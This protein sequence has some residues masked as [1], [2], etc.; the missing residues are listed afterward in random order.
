M[1]LAKVG[2]NIGKE[3]IAWTKTSTK[4]LLAT[5]PVKVN[6]QDLKYAPILEKDVVQ[7]DKIKVIKDKLTKV[8]SSEYC[9]MPDFMARI[10]KD[11]KEEEKLKILSKMFEDSKFFSRVSTCEE[12]YGKNF[13]FAE[14]MSKLSK[15]TSQT[16]TKGKPLEDVLKQIS[17]GYY[18]TRPGS[19]VYRGSNNPPNTIGTFGR[20]DSWTT[21]YGDDCWGAYKEYIER[22][23]KQ[24]GNR[25]T[26][27][28]KFTLTRN[29][30][31]PAE[32]GWGAF[33]QLMVHPYP[34]E[35]AKNMEI[36]SKRYKV[37]QKLV[38]EY[39]LSGNLSLEQKKQAD[40]IISELYY[41]MAN[42]TPFERGSNGISD[43]L[44]RSQYSALGMS[45]PHVR[46]GIGLDLEAFCM[47]LDEYK[48]KWNSFFDII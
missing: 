37:Y 17:N 12:M 8:L 30:S 47:N 3:I 26:P 48:L 24:L 4:S 15:E 2:I 38:N 27:Y 18:K 23:D 42:T 13:E 22:L 11:A 36:I 34:D 43:V 46:K 28:K 1:G 29:P 5:R 33:N 20:L 16:I 6:I 45:K 10:Q 35:V 31:S 9:E 41:L 25:I 19:G 40:D 14:M 21:R 39:K 32:S 7:I 44:M